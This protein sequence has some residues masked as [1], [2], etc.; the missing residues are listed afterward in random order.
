LKVQ[1]PARLKRTK[2]IGIRKVLGATVYNL[3]TLLSKEF[4]LLVFISCLIAVPIASYFLQKW[5]QKYEYRTAISWW[6]FA[7]PSEAHC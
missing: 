3:W 1:V 2:E 4:V 5:L 6:V 7:V